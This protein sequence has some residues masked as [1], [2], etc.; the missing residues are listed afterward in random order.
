M[1]EFSY[2]MYMRSR[3][4]VSVFDPPNTINPPNV[5]ISP[6]FCRLHG[7]PLGPYLQLYSL[8]F[9]PFDRAAIF[10]V[11]LQGEWVAHG[12]KPT[13]NYRPTS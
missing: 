7:G 8:K 12:D 13:H 2:E 4:G 11:L 9:D 1:R 6:S 10:E 5:D 3:D